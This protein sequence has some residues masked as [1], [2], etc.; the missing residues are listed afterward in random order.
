MGSL[1]DTHRSMRKRKTLIQE[2]QAAGLAS[3]ATSTEQEKI[4]A[5][6]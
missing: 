3:C 6:A 4:G 5:I 1:A 2:I